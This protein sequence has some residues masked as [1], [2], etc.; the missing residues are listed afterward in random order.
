MAGQP[1]EPIEQITNILEYVTHRGYHQE[2]GWIGGRYYFRGRYF[3]FNE[4]HSLFPLE[5]K[6]STNNPDKTNIPK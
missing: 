4:F 6:F 2:V 1:K 3:D 5:L